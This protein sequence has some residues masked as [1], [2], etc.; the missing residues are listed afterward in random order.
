[1][2]HYRLLTIV[3]LSFSALSVAHAD[4]KKVIPKGECEVVIGDTQYTE[5]DPNSIRAAHGKVVWSTDEKFST[6]QTRFFNATKR[7]DMVFTASNGQTIY[8]SAE[9]YTLSCIKLSK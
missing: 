2:R 3:A 9:Q 1:M 5:V 7:S 6:P 4:I 8:A